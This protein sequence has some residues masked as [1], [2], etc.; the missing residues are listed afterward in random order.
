MTSPETPSPEPQRSMFGIG[1]GSW[2]AMIPA[3]TVL[4]FFVLFLVGIL[5]WFDSRID[6]VEMRLTAQIVEVKADLTNRIDE[7]KA[8]LRATETRLS[9]RI[10]RVESRLTDRIDEVKADLGTRIDQVEAGLGTRIDGVKAELAAGEARRAAV[11]AQ[12]SADIEQ[13]AA[14]VAENRA[15]HRELAGFVR[16]SRSQEPPAASDPPGPAP[17]Q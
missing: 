15:A 4:T 13:V 12:L 11:D 16:A 2:K 5:G 8:D 3:A 17:A 6:G 7:V 10:D 14:G 9:D 1:D